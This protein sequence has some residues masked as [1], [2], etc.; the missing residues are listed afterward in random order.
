MKSFCWISDY[1]NNQDDDEIQ[2]K[3]MENV[4]EE[5]VFV[6]L[7]CHNILVA[8][9]KCALIFV[10]ETTMDRIYD[11]TIIWWYSGTQTRPGLDPYS[12]AAELAVAWGQWQSKL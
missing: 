11:N 1:A 10:K 3:I 5:R 6:W 8:W 2:F 4:D 9:R 12:A 7:W